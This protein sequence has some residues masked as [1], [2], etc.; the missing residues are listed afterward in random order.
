MSVQ[1]MVKPQSI[2][3]QM[4]RPVTAAP[5]GS[6]SVAQTA[7]DIRPTNIKVNHA[8]GQ[9]RISGIVVQVGL[10]RANCW[11]VRGRT[12]DAI[13]THERNHFQIAILI[14][15]ELDRDLLSLTAGSAAELQTAANELL[16]EKKARVDALSDTFDRETD[17]GQKSAEQRRWE[18][19]IASWEHAG[20]VR[21]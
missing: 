4:Y 13:L 2:T 5:D 11:A 20:T 1:L 10:D 16:Q 8:N 18:A 12:T 6:D 3:W 14:A 19:Q 9:A 21:L 15:R 17:H 7:S